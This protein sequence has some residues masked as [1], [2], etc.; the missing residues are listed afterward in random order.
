MHVHINS[1]NCLL[2]LSCAHLQTLTHMREHTCAHVYT[3][4]HTH[5]F[6]SL[7]ISSQWLWCLF[8]L[9]GYMEI[10]TF[11]R[12]MTRAIT[13]AGDPH[14][15]KA[16][17]VVYF[18]APSSDLFCEHGWQK[19]MFFL[20]SSKWHHILVSVYLHVLTCVSVHHAYED[21]FWGQK[22]VSDFLDLEL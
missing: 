11:L 19:I 12:V 6:N 8:P 5:Y 17:K 22:W 18:R 14:D 21:A 13:T 16:H 7:Y 15:H 2:D 9:W 10:C 1:E 4:M 3:H 20:F